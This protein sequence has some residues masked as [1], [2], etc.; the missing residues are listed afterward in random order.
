MQSSGLA[1]KLTAIGGGRRLT[2]DSLPSE[3]SLAAAIRIVMQTAQKKLDSIKTGP[4]TGTKVAH[5]STLSLYECQQ[6]M[7]NTFPTEYPPPSESSVNRSMRPDGGIVSVTVGERWHPLL[8]TEDKI[9]GTNDLRSAN[10]Q[11]RQATGNAIERAAKNIRGAEMAFLDPDQKLFPYVLFAA[12]CDFH[13]SETIAQ[14]LEMMN[15]GIPNTTFEVTPS[16]VD[17]MSDLIDRIKPMSCK[18][19]FGGRCV[20]SVFIKAHKWDEM[21]HGASN[22]TPAERTIVCGWAMEQSMEQ[23]FDIY[24]QSS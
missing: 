11:A 15:Y 21:D 18:K 14:R 24:G 8:I 9:Q 20:A 13:S 3:G 1:T 6:R 7:H 23:L 17:I 2:R 4:L 12:G 19:R 5:Q 22:W 16:N 10:G